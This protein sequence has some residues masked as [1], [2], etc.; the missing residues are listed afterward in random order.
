MREILLQLLLG[1]WMV[2]SY[3]RQKDQLL[4]QVLLLIL[5]G[6]IILVD[7]SV[8]QIIAL[9]SQQNNTWYMLPVSINISQFSIYTEL[10]SRSF[11]YMVIVEIN[12]NN[13]L[14]K[15]WPNC[16]LPYFLLQKKSEC[17]G[18]IWFK[19]QL[20]SYFFLHYPLH[21]LV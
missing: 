15:D 21:K 1:R 8:Q 14:L 6:V 9:E 4:G 17:I 10:S 12:I 3:K 18:C 13:C 20:L 2:K 19:I 5:P 16:Q 11:V 7:T